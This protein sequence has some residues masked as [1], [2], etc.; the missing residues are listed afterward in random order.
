MKFIPV[1]NRDFEPASHEDP[2]QPGVMKRVIAVKGQLL[3]GRVQMINWAQLPIE[4]SFRPHYHEDMEE[5][6]V[7]LSGQAEMTVDGQLFSLRPGDTLVVA[8]SEVHS[9][10]N[11]GDCLVEYLVMGISSEANGKTVVVASESG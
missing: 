2:N 1:D 10:T 4:S 7:L 6:F 8:P 3:R 5:I 9:M 11:R